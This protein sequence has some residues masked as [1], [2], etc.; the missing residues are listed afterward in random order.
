[1]RLILIM[2]PY[3]ILLRKIILRQIFVKLTLFYFLLIF[4][5]QF[6]I[7]K[8]SIKA[9]DFHLIEGQLVFILNQEKEFFNVSSMS[10]LQFQVHRDTLKS[11][12]NYTEDIS[13]T[14]SNYFQQFQ[15]STQG[16]SFNKI[17]IFL[18]NCL[19]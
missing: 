13:V 16:F 1:M 8:S 2:F 5:F 14:I 15:Y 7:I 18:K 3:F 19:F 6:G 11:L 12:E 17:N 4:L 9:D 10:G